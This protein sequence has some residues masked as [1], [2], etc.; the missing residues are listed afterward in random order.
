MDVNWFYVVGGVIMVLA[1]ILY[2]T[3]P[4]DDNEQQ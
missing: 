2:F 4:G 3:D 1:A